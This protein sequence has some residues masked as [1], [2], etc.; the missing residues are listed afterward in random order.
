MYDRLRTWNGNDDTGIK[1]V[2][3]KPSGRVST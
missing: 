1:V 3:V 2:L